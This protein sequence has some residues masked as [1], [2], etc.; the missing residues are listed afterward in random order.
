MICESA[1]LG[2]KWV[3]AFRIV[4]L[5]LCLYC[6][7][8]LPH[9]NT[10]IMVS[11]SYVGV[12]I[13]SLYLGLILMCECMRNPQGYAQSPPAVAQVEVLSRASMVRATTIF[14]EISFVT[15]V[16]ITLVFWI[17]MYPFMMLGSPRYTQSSMFFKVNFALLH[18]FPILTHVLEMWYN[19]IRVQFAHVGYPIAFLVVYGLMGLI[20]IFFANGLIYGTIPEQYLWV[21]A[22]LVVVA[23]GIVVL[24]QFVGSKITQNKPFVSNWT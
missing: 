10:V 22:P 2:R 18:I 11:L 12:V 13:V 15:N 7:C 5:V 17:A 9:G 14:Y 8:S 19:N 1:S 4:L 24:T 3:L 16:L 21:L 6:V 20:G 23:I